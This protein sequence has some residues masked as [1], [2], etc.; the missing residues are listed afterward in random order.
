[1]AQNAC[2]DPLAPGLE[3]ESELLPWGWLE[4]AHPTVTGNSELA[5]SD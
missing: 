4:S 3:S 1:V 2:P 5:I